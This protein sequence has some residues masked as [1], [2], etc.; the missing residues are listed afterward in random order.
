MK[1]TKKETNMLNRRLNKMMEGDFLYVIFAYDSAT[2]RLVYA[3]TCSTLDKVKTKLNKYS[4]QKIPAVKAIRSKG[5]KY[6]AAYLIEHNGNV[7]PVYTLYRATETINRLYK[8]EYKTKVR[9]ADKEVDCGYM[10][11]A[12]ND[13]TDSYVCTRLYDDSLEVK[14]HISK[15]HGV[16][17][18]S[19]EVLD[20][21]KV[22][23]GFKFIDKRF[24]NCSRI[25]Q[26]K[27][28]LL[29]SNKETVEDLLQNK[30]D[31]KNTKEALEDILSNLT[32]EQMVKVLADAIK[33]SKE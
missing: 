7:I 29:E 21:I 5:S 4:M 8:T 32:E 28:S 22:K 16:D 25:K 20:V 6:N 19:L 26:V 3:N 23:S 27:A 30:F 10:G 12:Y 14:S 15:R 9:K 18:S 33:E 13:K 24:D 17:K 1:Y 11:F 2:K 31:S